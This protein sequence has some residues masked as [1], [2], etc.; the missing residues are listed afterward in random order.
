MPVP[1]P[2]EQVV[3]VDLVAP[4][5]DPYP[6]MTDQPGTGGDLVIKNAPARGG[7]FNSSALVIILIGA[8]LIYI[9][10]KGTWK[11]VWA[12][13]TPLSG[14]QL[15]QQQ[16]MLADKS[17][18]AIQRCPPGYTLVVSPTGKQCVKL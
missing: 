12:A 14:N 15:T 1:T 5:K 11:Q 2:P 16:A 3:P 6:R 9:A 7:G 17:P 13:F 10:I 4:R 18:S 8:G